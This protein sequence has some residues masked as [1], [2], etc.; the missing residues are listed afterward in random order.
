MWLHWVLLLAM[1]W[2]MVPYGRS[3][4]PDVLRPLHKP[5]D[6][7]V[8][9]RLAFQSNRQEAE[10]AGWGTDFPM[11]SQNLT[12]RFSELT[13]A[14][15]PPER[16]ARPPGYGGTTGAGSTVPVHWAVPVDSSDLFLCPFLLASDVGTMSI[17]TTEA[18]ALRDYFE[19]GGMLWVDDYWGS[20]SQRQWEG[21]LGQVL[22]GQWPYAPDWEHPVYNQHYQIRNHLQ[23]SNVGSR[24]GDDTWR[25]S[26]RGEDSP[27]TPLQLVN[28]SKG[29][30][31]IIMTHNSDVADGWER[32]GESEAYTLEYGFDSYALGINVLL[33]A[34]SH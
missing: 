31:A 28:N 19:K 12:I 32:D 9:C 24:R 1:Q 22:P 33:Y 15:I 3:V 16:R 21:V 23:M 18:L 2:P 11:A 29:D 30:V 14:H 4:N 17:T 26:E 7:I 6:G 5:D 34:L 27:L 8:L 25:A 13:T 10:G 20:A